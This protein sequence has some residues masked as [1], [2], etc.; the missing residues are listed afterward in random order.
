MVVAVGVRV[1]TVVV[2]VVVGGHCR[3]HDGCGRGRVDMVVV[4]VVVMHVVVV[5]CGRCRGLLL[6]LRWGSR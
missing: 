5:D 3:G 6:W 1:D 4:V 2:V